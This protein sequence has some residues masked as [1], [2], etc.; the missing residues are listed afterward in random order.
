MTRSLQWL[1]AL[2]L[3]ISVGAWLSRPG[4]VNYGFEPKGEKAAVVWNFL[5]EQRYDPTLWTLCTDSLPWAGEGVPALAVLSPGPATYELH[6]VEPYHSTDSRAMWW[7]MAM[8]PEQ[9][10]RAPVRLQR[11]FKFSVVRFSDDGQ[12]AGFTFLR[13]TLHP[14]DA[15]ASLGW[16]LMERVGPGWT[17]RRSMST[18]VHPEA[19]NDPARHMPR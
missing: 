1:V 5:R 18:E 7:A 9:C 3:F 10:A 16:A 11:W 2:V 8:T 13:R 6:W 12:T 19:L 14:Q 4:Y 17:I 15:A